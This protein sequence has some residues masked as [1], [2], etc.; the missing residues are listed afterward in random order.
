MQ[1]A[2]DRKL[3]LPNGQIGHF[4][5]Y[6]PQ[7]GGLVTAEVRKQAARLIPYTD[8][9]DE[10]EKI[11]MIKSRLNKGLTPR[12]SSLRSSNKKVDSGVV[13][14]LL[15]A[16]CDCD[17][18]VK[19][20]VLNSIREKLSTYNSKEMMQ[21]IASFDSDVGKR[22]VFSWWTNNLIQGRLKYGIGSLLGSGILT[23]PSYLTDILASFK[24]EDQFVDQ[25]I[26]W[27]SH[28]REDGP[29]A[30]LSPRDN[31]SH[32]RM[33]VGKSGWG[34]TQPFIEAVLVAMTK[35]SIRKAELMKRFSNAIADANAHKIPLITDSIGIITFSRHGAINRLPGSLANFSAPALEGLGSL[36]ALRA[37][38]GVS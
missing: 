10:K 17:D 36:E 33:R 7:G 30:H 20:D 16:L 9:L 12:S 19:K 21:F 29:V 26:W 5:D 31:R 34:T 28:I 24:K 14:G 13:D 18:A 23:N 11:E 25:S 37:Y 2:A 32:F 27:L 4:L 35:K 6:D 1:A 22:E 3:S 15:A 38:H 8:E